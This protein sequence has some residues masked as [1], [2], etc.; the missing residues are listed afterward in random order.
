M[1]KARGIMCRKEAAIST[2][3]A[4][5]MKYVVL[6]CPQL[7]NRRIVKIP[8]DVTRAAD[9]L[10]PSAVQKV[11]ATPPIHAY[12]VPQRPGAGRGGVGFPVGGGPGAV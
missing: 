4:K 9:M 10:V 11:F 2:P 3:A 7:V 12:E 6:L 8:A 5:H 1:P